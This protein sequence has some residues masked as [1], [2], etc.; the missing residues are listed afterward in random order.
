MPINNQSSADTY[1][2]ANTLA[3]SPPASKVNMVVA[4]A[5]VYV[6]F[7]DAAN[8]SRMPQ[9]QSWL[10]E[11][12]YPPGYYNVNRPTGPNRSVNGIRFRSAVS[13][14]PAQVTVIAI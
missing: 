8:D 3:V 7:S 9:S 10:P 4:N 5:A 13:G 11:Q 6:Q 1:T 14:T 12:F 2:S